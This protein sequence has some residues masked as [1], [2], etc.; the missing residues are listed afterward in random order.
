MSDVQKQLAFA[1]IGIV[2]IVVLVLAFGSEDFPSDLNDGM[3]VVEDGAVYDEGG[4]LVGEAGR[5]GRQHII[6]RRT[7]PTFVVPE[8]QEGAIANVRPNAGDSNEKILDWQFDDKADETLSWNTLS[9]AGVEIRSEDHYVEVIAT[10]A[11]GGEITTVR[12]GNSGLVVVKSHSGGVPELEL[13]N[14]NEAVKVGSKG[15]WRI[16]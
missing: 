6:L 4:N 14:N 13:Y 5:R 11:P 3:Y 15:W 10:S 2:A 7:K 1:V 12:F 9:R 8:T 16:G